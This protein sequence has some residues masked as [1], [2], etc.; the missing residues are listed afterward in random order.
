MAFDNYKS[1]RQVA[2]V[3]HLR[4]ITGSLFPTLAVSDAPEWLAEMYACRQINGDLDLP[5]W[6]I[7]TTG[8]LWRFG[9]FEGDLFTRHL[10]SYNLY[11][12][13]L[14]L[15]ALHYVFKQCDDA[16]Q[17]AAGVEVGLF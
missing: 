17:K 5:V 4:S 3:F 7:V 16:A 11:P 2:G 13:G 9:K 14:L 10:E 12:L 8:E 1:V 15:T 6:G